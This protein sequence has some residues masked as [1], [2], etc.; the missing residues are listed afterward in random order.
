MQKSNAL[1][2]NETFLDVPR[3]LIQAINHPIFKVLKPRKFVFLENKS[4]QTVSKREWVYYHSVRLATEKI[5]GGKTRKFVTYQY[6]IPRDLPPELWKKEYLNAQGH[7]REWAR[8]RVFENIN[9][10]G[11]AE[12]SQELLG[13][14]KKALK[15]GH[16]PFKYEIDELNRLKAEAAKAVQ[17]AAAKIPILTMASAIEIFLKAYVK[18][19]PTYNAHLVIKSLLM[20]GLGEGY[21]QDI[22]TITAP[23]LQSMLQ[24]MFE[25][26]EWS[27]ATFND[28]VK[29][30]GT[31]YKALVKK[32]LIPVDI[33][34]KLEKKTK[35][36]KTKNTPFDAA[37]ATLIKDLMLNHPLQPTGKHVYDFC[38]VVYYTCTRPDKETRQ[39]KCK[40][41]LWDRGLIYIDPERAKGGA[42]GHIPLCQE[43]ADLFREMGVDKGAPEDYI[44][45]KECVPGPECFKKGHFSW[46][47][48]EHII[49]PNNLNRDFVPYSWKPT[50][51]IHLHKDGANPYDIQQL[52]RH[53]SLAQTM[54]YMRDLGLIVSQETNQKTRKF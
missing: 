29:K 51:V 10:I 33:S 39:L 17:A 46:F 49:K 18:D 14:V 9:R 54:E 25:E 30:L 23:D 47:F 6:R 34:L 28:K 52:C 37:S 19:S 43:L 35:V 31:F 41:I 27:K 13:S 15:E 53:E 42:G 44:F 4:V 32:D 36:A 48:R 8:I 40:D 3:P 7:L 50:R 22:L 1:K 26:K 38:Q 11:D 20:E 5:T 2:I 24:E 12:N 16:D 21:D 45:G